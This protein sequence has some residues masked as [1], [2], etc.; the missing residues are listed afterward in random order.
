M[1]IAFGI[2]AL[3]GTEPEI[4]LGELFT[5]AK[6]VLKNTIATLRLKCAKVAMQYIRGYT[7]IFYSVGAETL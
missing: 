1:G 7:D 4:H 6:Y 3:G 2:L 5:I